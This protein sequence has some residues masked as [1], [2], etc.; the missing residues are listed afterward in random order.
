MFRR[1][2]Q[3]KVQDYNKLKRDQALDFNNSNANEDD[4]AFFA[5]D[6]NSLNFDSINKHGLFDDLKYKECQH[7]PIDDSNYDVNNINYYLQSRNY[8]NFE[9][10]KTLLG[11]QKSLETKLLKSYEAFDTDGFDSD[12]SEYEVDTSAPTGDPRCTNWMMYKNVRN[13][14]RNCS[15]TM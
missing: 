7:Q 5:N 2:L 14:R 10:A 8:K 13:R 9:G 12:D 3:D 11:S 4:R 1:W 15:G 6:E